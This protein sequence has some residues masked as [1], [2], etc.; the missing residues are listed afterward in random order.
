MVVSRGSALGQNVTKNTTC[1]PSQGPCFEREVFKKNL[2][3]LTT[4]VL[5]AGWKLNAVV[6]WEGYGTGLQETAAVAAEEGH[7]VGV[8]YNDE[9]AAAAA[10][11]PRPE[12]FR[13]FPANYSDLVASIKAGYKTQELASPLNI[14]D[15]I[16]AGKDTNTTI[17]IHL[18]LY[19]HY[20]DAWGWNFTTPKQLQALV[21]T[22]DKRHVKVVGFMMHLNGYPDEKKMPLSQQFLQIAARIWRVMCHLNRHPD[23]ASKMPLS[24]QFL[25]VACPVAASLAPQKVA[26]HWVN[27]D[28]ALELIPKPN[29]R[30]GNYR[31]QPVIPAVCNNAS[32][33]EYWAR[34]GTAIYGSYVENYAD[35]AEGSG[36]GTAPVLRWTSKV[37]SVGE[38]TLPSGAVRK[39]AVVDLGPAR[40]PAPSWWSNALVFELANSTSVNATN[41][42]AAAAAAVDNAANDE[43]VDDDEDDEEDAAAPSVAAPAVAATAGTAGRR[44]LQAAAATPAAPGTGEDEDDGEEDEDEEGDDDA[45]NA[46][47]IAAAAP[48]RFGRPPLF[49][50]INH[51]RLQLADWPAGKGTV[52]LVDITHAETPVVPGDEVCLLCEERPVGSFGL[53]V[54]ADEYNMA[55]CLRG[56]GA[57]EG[58]AYDDPNCKPW[59]KVQ[60]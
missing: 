20:D 9:V 56:M 43:D 16:K 26:V 19:M 31:M 48:D 42:T 35:A 5:P 11:T 13:M 52:I 34:M 28:E 45:D 59:A 55:L 7:S 17:P 27:S 50:Y 57:T 39:V 60:Q 44:L 14:G 49:V 18:Y 51:Q 23:V 30:Y 10:V 22:L 21:D 41:T 46:E 8:L 12:I 1:S 37:K 36:P 3:Y 47:G 33:I 25:Q 40:F 24:Q 38:T 4:A 6:K 15:L 58:T 54:G 32:N 53:E 2:Q 29:K